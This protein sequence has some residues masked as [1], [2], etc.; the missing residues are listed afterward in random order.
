MDPNP[1]SELPRET[2]STEA[3]WFLQT[4][5]V[6]EIVLR[7]TVVAAGETTETTETDR[8]SDEIRRRRTRKNDEDFW[9]FG[10]VRVLLC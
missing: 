7:T 4:L 9:G 3:E 5:R 2:P 10:W 1:R 8:K 6:G